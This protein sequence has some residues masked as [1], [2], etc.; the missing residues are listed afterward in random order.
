MNPGPITHH[1]PSASSVIEGESPAQRWQVRETLIA[2][3]ARYLEAVDC[4]RA[5]DCEPSWRIDRAS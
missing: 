1:H 2:E 3:I 4:F 5:L